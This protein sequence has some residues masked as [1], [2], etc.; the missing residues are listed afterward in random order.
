[1]GRMVDLHHG[2]VDAEHDDYRRLHNPV[3]HRRG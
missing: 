2:V 1:M 3:L